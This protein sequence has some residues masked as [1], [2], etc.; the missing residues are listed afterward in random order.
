MRG[1]DGVKAGVGDDEKTAVGG[2]VEDGGETGIGDVDADVI[3]VDFDA[4]DAGGREAVK[5][6]LDA[7]TVGVD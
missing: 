7:V 6:S 2:T 5:L 1:R 4:A 3:G